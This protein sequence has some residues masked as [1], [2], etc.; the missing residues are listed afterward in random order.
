M[1]ALMHNKN[2][3]RYYSTELENCKAM[4]T[5]YCLVLFGHIYVFWGLNI[6]KYSQLMRNVFIFEKIT[7]TSVFTLTFLTSERQLLSSCHPYESPWRIFAKMRRFSKCLGPP[8]QE[9]EIICSHWKW[10][11]WLLWWL[12]VIMT[13]FLFVTSS[14]DDQL[15]TPCFSRS[16]LKRGSLKYVVTNRLN[17]I[18]FTKVPLH[19]HEKEHYI[20]VEYSTNL[21]KIYRSSIQ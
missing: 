11:L 4:V 15:K 2:F 17:V 10:N 13:S 21:W 19:W 9:L 6:R 7:P 18:R 8:V 3:Y 20:T 16:I 14:I 1:K 5:T 12:S